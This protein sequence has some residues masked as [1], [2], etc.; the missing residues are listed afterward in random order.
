MK[1]VK[2]G[3]LS[4]K[5]AVALVLLAL[6]S[7]VVS[8][9]AHMPG[10]KAPP[11]FKLPSIVISD[12][13]EEIEITIEDVGKYHNKQMKEFK[14]KIS[15]VLGETSLKEKFE[16]LGIKEG[17]EITLVG[18]ETSTPVRK[19]GNYVLAKIGEQLVTVGRGLAEKVW[20]E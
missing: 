18:K 7:A 6:L 16:E 14:R 13:G 19:G 8:V 1:K 11:A 4:K 9:N 10:A 20:V 3:R 2:S 5:A 12:D 17:K 15:K